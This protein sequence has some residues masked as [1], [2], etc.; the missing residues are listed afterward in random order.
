MSTRTI[1]KLRHRA[2]IGANRRT[3]QPKLERQAQRAGNPRAKRTV[4]D[5][6]RQKLAQKYETHE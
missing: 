3:W 6:I 4:A 1:R 2:D 5:V